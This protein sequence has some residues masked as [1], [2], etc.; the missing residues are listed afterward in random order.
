MG[1]RKRFKR[2]DGSTTW[3]LILVRSAGVFFILCHSHTLLMTNMLVGLF[4]PSLSP[5]KPMHL[6]WYLSLV[7]NPTMEFPMEWRILRVEFPGKIWRNITRSA[8]AAI[9]LLVIHISRVGGWG[10]FLFFFVT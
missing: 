1:K 5:T 9:S 10:E 7:P 8:P 4:K 6:L 2:F 3:A